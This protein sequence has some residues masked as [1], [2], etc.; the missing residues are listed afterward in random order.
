MTACT[1]Q[2]PERPPAVAFLVADS[3]FDYVQE[4][5]LGFGAGVERV[6]G[7]RHDE[8][9]SEIGDTT[10]Q[11]AMLD[12]LRKSHRGGVSVFTQS[13]ELF[14]GSLA[15]AAEAGT[16]MVAVNS[17]PAAG[18]DV[19]LYIGN[20]NRQLGAML[21]RQA[22]DRLPAAADG[23]V[24]LG[25]SVPGAPSLDLRAAAIRDELL[26]LRPAL[27][28]LGP[29][30]TKQDPAANRDAWQTL[31]EANP[32]AL[33]FLGTGDAD[34]CNLAWVRTRT[35]GTWVAGGFSLDRRALLAA[36]SHRIVLVSPEPFVQG[37]VAGMLQAAHAAR[38]RRLPRGWIVTPALAVTA[39]NV[40]EI[41]RRQESLANRTAWALPQVE[42][43]VARPEAYLRPVGEAG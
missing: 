16:P 3:P 10:Q 31:V 23:V 13:P 7:V 38:G 21:A 32:D 11:L 42:A 27:R 29:F 39:A 9:G 37:A 19:S 8:T 22:A 40:E 1:A 41:M 25:T 2:R 34:A 24:I 20:D 6:G 18:S 5:T 4:M 14:A 30:D 15:Q 33:A 17:P 36:R 35:A 12:T 43:I 26:R 28:V